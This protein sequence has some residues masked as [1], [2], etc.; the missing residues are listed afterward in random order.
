[1]RLDM[2]NHLDHHLPPPRVLTCRNARQQTGIPVVIR[3]L[4]RLT[5]PRKR[6]NRIPQDRKIF[7]FVFFIKQ[8]YRVYHVSILKQEVQNVN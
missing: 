5:V 6:T 2:K 3:R 4:L 1:M 7:I 8:F